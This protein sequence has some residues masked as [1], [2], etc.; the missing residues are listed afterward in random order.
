[1]F[2]FCWPSWSCFFWR[3][4]GFSPYLSQPYQDLGGS[5]VLA[6][7]FRGGNDV[8]QSYLYAPHCEM[9]SSYLT[10]SNFVSDIGKYQRLPIAMCDH[11]LRANSLIRTLLAVSIQIFIDLVENLDARANAWLVVREDGESRFAWPHSPLRWLCCSNTSFASA[12]WGE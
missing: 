8:S 12:K 7:V 3:H 1:M 2:F 11:V 6:P 10:P 5:V 9:P 4:G